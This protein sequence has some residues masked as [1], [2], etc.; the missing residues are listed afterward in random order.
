MV[1]QAVTEQRHLRLWEAAHTLVAVVAVEVTQGLVVLVVQAGVV[2]VAVV[3]L[4]LVLLRLQTQAVAVVA[5]LVLLLAV[6][7]VL[8]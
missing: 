3:V 8:A 6:K 1:E 4:L 2:L 5:L 7:A